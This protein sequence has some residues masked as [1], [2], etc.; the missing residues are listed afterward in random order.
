MSHISKCV[1]IRR[2][3]YPSASHIQAYHTSKCL[4][5]SNVSHIKVLIHPVSHIIMRIHSMPHIIMLIHSVSHTSK[6]LTQSDVSHIKVPTHSVSHTPSVSHIQ[7]YHTSKCLF[8]VPHNHAYSFDASH[9]QVHIRCLTPPSAS[10]IQASHTFGRLTYHSAYSFSVS[11]IQV[12]HP[13]MSIRCP[14]YP[15]AY[16]VG[17]SHIQ[18]PSIIN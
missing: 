16:S 7:A 13:I 3:T 12:S 6:C 1:F 2:P 10:H 11:H 4:T 15:S 17:V 18:V 14:T 9:I 8:I 5:H